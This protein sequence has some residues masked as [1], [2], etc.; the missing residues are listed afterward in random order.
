MSSNMGI[1]AGSSDGHELATMFSNSELLKG[2]GLVEMVLEVVEEVK[3]PRGGG[4]GGLI[5]S[6]GDVK[7]DSTRDV[8]VHP[9]DQPDMGEM[10]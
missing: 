4:L 2:I 8:F 10:L 9:L 7:A 1:S 5:R 6:S 3:G